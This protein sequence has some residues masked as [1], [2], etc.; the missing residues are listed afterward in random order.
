[1]AAILLA[2]PPYSLKQRYGGLAAAGSALPHMGLLMLAAVLAE[3]GHQVRILDAP[4]QGLWQEEIL[5]VARSFR[6]DMVGLGSV[7]A[8]MGS[9]GVLA[10]RLKN[11]CPETI[12]VGGGPHVTAIP[13]AVLAQ[14]P[15][16]DYLV[17]GEGERTFPELVSALAAGRPGKVV[18][19]LMFRE[20]GQTGKSPARA[21]IEELDELP[22][23]AWDLL[24][25]FPKRFLPALFRYRKFPAAHLVT[26]RGCP[27]GCV[28]CDTGVFGKKLRMHSAA[29]VL[30]AME[31]LYT[32]YG[33]R[34]ILFEDD[35]F[36]ADE[37]RARAICQGLMSRGLGISWSC[38]ARV[39]N[40]R[41]SD[42]LRLLA[43]AGCWQISYGIESGDQGILDRAGKQ[44]TREL[45]RKAMENTRRAKIRTKGFFILGLPGETPNTMRQTMEF[46]L[47]LALDDANVF[48][49]TPFPGTRL[50]EIAGNKQGE[51]DRM[52]VFEPVFAPPGISTKELKAMQRRFLSGFYK[53]PGIV[54]DYLKRLVDNPGQFWRMIK[55][56]AGFLRFTTM[57]GK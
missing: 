17:L 25:G 40:V 11:I 5:D 14:Y 1:M 12:V 54:F 13:E 7:T 9:A 55:G 18:P 41:D 32:K 24:E 2:N 29:W 36:L 39:D 26:S 30:E 8:S 16:L 22:L 45:I 42:L 43:R 37:S 31:V 6:P 51:Y 53:R 52:N 23:P 35:R 44:I 57:G 28:F 47:D 38:L 34:E 21:L 48:M 19:G 33:V 50:N 20:N 46:A 15:A 3:K 4:A 27:H 49:A 10:K 56:L